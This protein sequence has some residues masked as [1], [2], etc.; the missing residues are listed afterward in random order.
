MPTWKPSGAPR[1]VGWSRL[2]Q[3]Y[4]MQLYWSPS[5]KRYCRVLL[6][7][8]DSIILIKI[9]L[10]LNCCWRT[11]ALASCWGWHVASP[12]LHFRKVGISSLLKTQKLLFLVCCFSV[13]L[14]TKTRELVKKKK[15]K[16][17][18]P[19]KV[20]QRCWLESLISPDST[21]KLED[22]HSKGLRLV[23][24]FIWEEINLKI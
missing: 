1:N 10:V 11:L 17:T 21:G 23:F 24:K 12:F 6:P 15:E 4:Q 3:S 16:K 14:Q 19:N 18:I 8:V 9:E 5:G 13:G 7:H 22:F 2:G 20:A